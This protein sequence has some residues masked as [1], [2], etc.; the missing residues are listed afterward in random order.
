MHKEIKT[1][2]MLKPSMS[3]FSQWYILYYEVL[4]VTNAIFILWNDVENE[5]KNFEKY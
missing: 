5:T 2:I 4:S 3:E 1:R